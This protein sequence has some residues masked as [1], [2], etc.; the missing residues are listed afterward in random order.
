M[1]CPLAPP[2]RLFRILARIYSL[3]SNLKL[4][5]VL[6]LTTLQGFTLVVTTLTLVGVAFG[7]LP[8]LPSNRASI[9]FMGTV[10]L[11]V[12][13]V[14]TPKAAWQL[15]D[16]E[17][18]LLLLALMVLNAYL[19]EAGF[20]ELLTHSTVARVRRSGAL[21]AALCFASGLLSAFFLNDTVVLILTPLVLRV[22][23]ALGRKPVPYLIALATSANVGSVATLTGNPQN[24]IIGV[25]SGIGY[26]DFLQALGPV[27]VVGLVIV[28]G[29]VRL[30]YPDEF[31]GPQSRLAAATV[32]PTAPSRR[33]V[34][35]VAVVTLGMLGAF[36]SGLP[37][38]LA[39]LGAAALLLLV[40]GVTPDRI[41]AKVD[42][43]L[44]V[45]FGGLFVVV[46]SLE[47]TGLSHQLFIATTPL[48]GGGKTAL[49]ALTLVLSNL[50]SNVPAVLLLTPVVAKLPQSASAYLTVAMASTLAGNL[51]LVGSVANLIVAEGARRG[52][53]TLSF[54]PYLK[55]GV[56]ITLVTLGVGIVWLSL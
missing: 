14:V 25:A 32:K 33:L 43:N 11:L 31:G 23:E 18:V 37:V 41:F 50:L 1:D 9:T 55:L 21:L 24:L 17:V 34:A 19:S 46:G 8:F 27:A 13:G 47:V 2:V 49:S 3:D 40:G 26:L 51:T 28:I 44:L 45:L 30:S 22:T 10:T 52:G 56:P 5:R 12:G 15:I 16:G 4:E 20:F 48:L 54:W 39:A 35:T 36:L 38:T 7:R 29:V 42:W 6:S 53:V